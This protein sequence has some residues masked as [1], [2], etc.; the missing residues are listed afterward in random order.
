MQPLSE[1]VGTVIPSSAILLGV[2][3]PARG[4]LSASDCVHSL[5]GR[6]GTS[7]WQAFSKRLRPFACWALRHQHVASFQQAV[8]SIRLLGVE[9]PA[10]GELSASDCV[11]SLAV[12]DRGTC[13]ISRPKIEDENKARQRRPK[14]FFRLPLPSVCIAFLTSQRITPH[15]TCVSSK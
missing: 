10:R 13:D 11:H 1:S 7:T 15:I 2:E 8:A 12:S 14:A 9:A 4:K 5:A 6:R 3:A